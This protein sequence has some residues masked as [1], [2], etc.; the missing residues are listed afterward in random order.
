MS[1]KVI[2]FDVKDTLGTVDRPGHLVVYKPSTARLVE[3]LKDVVGLRAGII[4]NLPKSVAA[5]AGRRMLDEA[6]I[7]PWLDENGIII[8]HEVDVS[9]PT[10]RIYQ[11][12]AERMDVGVDECI[13]VGENLIEVIGAEAAGMKGVLKPSPPGREFKLK[14]IEARPESESDSGRLIET[15]LE[16]DHLIGKRITICAAAIAKRL[17]RDDEETPHWQ[18]STLVWLLQNFID[19]FH[20]RKEERVVMP[21]AAARGAAQEVVDQTLREHDQ[22]R[23]YFDAMA[24]ALGRYRA[25]DEAAKADFRATTESFVALYKEHA[26]R[27]NDELLPEFGRLLTPEDDTLMVDLVGQVGPADL[28]PYLSLIASLEKSL[29]LEPS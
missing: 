17:A 28:A 9:K 11:L 25:G 26:R 3:T 8:N 14:P 19:P 5:E 4:M 16:E 13:F 1:A 15:I 24:A 10:E 12:A 23:A 2:F 20:H 27:E 29:G 6:G 18:M 21:L 7:T 22:G